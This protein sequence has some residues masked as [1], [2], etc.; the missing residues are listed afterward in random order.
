MRNTRR[1]QK[2]QVFVEV[3]CGMFI[4]IPIALCALDLIVLVLGNSANDSLAK[5]CARAAANEQDL[6]KAKAAAAQVV[7][8]FPKSPLI[9]KVELDNAKLD[10]NSKA[11]V[12]AET[13]ITVRIPI[14][15]PGTVSQVNFRARAT[16]P[17][18]G[19]SAA[20]TSGV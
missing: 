6:S 12:T 15:L 10:F 4:L 5:N 8:H 16:E 20:P 7:S 9:E 18:V 13:I 19:V 14:T 11:N 17:V 3:L 2:G 1:N